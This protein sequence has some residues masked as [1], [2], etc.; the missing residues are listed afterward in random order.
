MSTL[1][2]EGRPA[3]LRSYR[4]ALSFRS[5]Y[6]AEYSDP[7]DKILPKLRS[8]ADLRVGV[9]FSVTVNVL[10]AASLMSELRQVLEELGLTGA[11]WIE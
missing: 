3:A 5:S 6:G 11:V 4:G 9:D 2:R 1:K 10:S 7:S 8:G